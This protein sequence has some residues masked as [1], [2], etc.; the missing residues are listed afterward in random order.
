VEL[1]A[2][3]EATFAF[4][5]ATHPYELPRKDLPAPAVSGGGIL[6]FLASQNYGLALVI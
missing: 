5:A 1:M 3:I 6:W 2:I 4:N